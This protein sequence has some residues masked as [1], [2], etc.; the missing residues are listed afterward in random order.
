M[1][2]ESIKIK[3][4]K[5]IEDITIPISKT[6]G[7]R[8]ITFI[9]KN[10]SGKSNILEAINIAI[11]KNKEKYDFEKISNRLLQPDKIAIS[12]TYNICGM[13]IKETLNSKNLHIDDTLVKKLNLTKLTDIYT[14]DKGSTNFVHT[15]SLEHSTVKI[16]KYFIQTIQLPSNSIGINNALKHK[17]DIAHEDTLAP[18]GNTGYK[19]LDL[20]T[21]EKLLQEA[22]LIVIEESKKGG[23][24][25]P[26]PE[27]LL[28]E[29]INLRE[30]AENPSKCVPLKNIFALHGEKDKNSI[31]TKINSI[32][33]SSSS[34]RTLS[35]QLSKEASEF[36]KERWQEINARIDINIESSLIASINVVDEQNDEAFYSM[37]ERSQGFKSFVSLLLSVSID[38]YE[39]QINGAIITIDEPETHL[40]PS[41]VRWLLNELLK[42][43]EKNNIL[44][45][46]HSN[47]LIDKQSKTRH[48]ITEKSSSGVTNI[49][50]V[51]ETSSI[52]G[53]EV[54]DR[55]FGIDPIRDFISKY[56]ILVEGAC[57]KELISNTLKQINPTFEKD[58]K[59]INGH[60]NNIQTLASFSIIHNIIP[61]VITDDDAQGKADRNRVKEI[62]NEYENR[63]F[64][65]KELNQ[66]LP[67]GSTIEDCVS[68]K[69]LKDEAIVAYPDLRESIEATR[70]DIPFLTQLTGILKE[71][72]GKEFNAKIDTFKKSVSKIKIDKTDKQLIKVGEAIIEKLKASN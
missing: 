37:E 29:Q 18:F 68:F 16:D 35:R 47:F 10:E 36:L 30:F 25:N 61:L 28:P 9:G 27:Y 49:T 23:L 39:G 21:L 59:I 13:D 38:N 22:M 24:W 54:L 44:I 71:H 33:S 57:D 53:D 67:N 52:L 70:E 12:F 45:A 1:E 7:S 62:S 65:I 4:Y 58:T 31:L 20:S 42:I 69:K 48:F 34:R 15:I 66:D 3:G 46:T 43:G 2:L 72:Y 55:A 41:G 50:Q 56:Q 11:F 14:L 63:A 64:T 8:L 40:H 32:S 17:Y 51:E 60:G 26:G 19:Q 5:S 6:N